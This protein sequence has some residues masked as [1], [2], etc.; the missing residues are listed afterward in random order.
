MHTLPIVSI[1]I[2]AVMPLMGAAGAKWG[3]KSYDNNNP[4]AWLAQQTGFRARSNAAQ[5]NSFEA[6]P[7]F[8]AGVLLSLW[9]HVDAMCLDAICISFLVLRFAFFWA[10]ITDRASLRSAVWGLAY[11]C[12]ISLY[13]ASL[14]A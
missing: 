6:F 11:L 12:C 13:V 2:A 14:F 10:Y 4:R 5:A 8:A 9:T 7:F 3:F 1:L